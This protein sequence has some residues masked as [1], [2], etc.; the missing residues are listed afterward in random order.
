MLFQ[1][2]LNDIHLATAAVLQSCS[3]NRR[4]ARLFLNLLVSAP[5]TSV[6]GSWPST[7]CPDL[8]CLPLRFRSL[9]RS[10]PA[11]FCLEPSVLSPLRCPRLAKIFRYQPA[12]PANLLACQCRRGKIPRPILEVFATRL[13]KI[14]AILA[15]LN[16]LHAGATFCLAAHSFRLSA[17]VNDQHEQ[18]WDCQRFRLTCYSCDLVDRGNVA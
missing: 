17:P 13:S 3:Y 15:I 2:S 14:A 16:V 6:R 9:L 1:H 7:I 4:R 12:E 5:Y 8:I 18:P 11:Q 10:D